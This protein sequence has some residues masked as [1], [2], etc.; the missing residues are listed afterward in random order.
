M[1][2]EHWV[3]E[4][5]ALRHL[6]TLHPTWTPAEL[7]ACLGQCKNW[8]KKWRKRFQEA[9]PDDRH[10]LFSQS[11]ARRTPPPPPHPLLVQRIL[12]LRDTPPENLQRTPGPGRVKSAS[13]PEI[14]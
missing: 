2:E 6:M 14:G 11:R 8:V 13:S 5:A 7:A 3:A 9:A 10:V 12:A 4:R 1:D